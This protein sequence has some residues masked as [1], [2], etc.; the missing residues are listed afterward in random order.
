VSAGL[1]LVRSVPALSQS[2]AKVSLGHAAAQGTT[3]PSAEGRRHSRQRVRLNKKLYIYIFLLT[4]NKS[5]LNTHHIA[6]RLQV[7]G[8]LGKDNGPFKA[9]GPQKLVEKGH[10][11]PAPLGTLARERA[12]PWNG[13]WRR[14]TLKMIIYFYCKMKYL[15]F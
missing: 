5:I 4:N 3:H 2:V 6:Q 13:F 8:D 11:V 14:W 12:C 7:V 15:Y 10:R 9:A 1:W